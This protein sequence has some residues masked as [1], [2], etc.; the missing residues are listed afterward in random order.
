MTVTS[1]KRQDFLGRW[2]VNTR[3]GTSNTTDF[4]GRDAANGT[5]D[6]LGRALAFDNPGAWGAGA[7]KVAGAYVKPLAGVNY[8]AVFVALDAGTTAAVTEPTWPTT[9]GGTVVDNVGASSIT[10]KCVHA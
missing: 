5:T 7:A 2:L 3:P 10:W 9:V 8:D 1:T 6:Y 4:L